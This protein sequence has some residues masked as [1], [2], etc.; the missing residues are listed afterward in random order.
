MHLYS[1]ILIGTVSIA[2]LWG[3]YSSTVTV[4]SFLHTTL[5]PWDFLSDFPWAQRYYKL[6]I[7]IVGYIALN[8]RSTVY[9]SI[10]TSGGTKVSQAANNETH[11]D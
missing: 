2:T 3:L 5:P 1:A 6:F 8:A 4:C 9:Q 10:S 11:K 7:F